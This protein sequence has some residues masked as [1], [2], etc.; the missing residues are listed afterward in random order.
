MIK[1]FPNWASVFDTAEYG[2]L[3]HV[4][5]E[6]HSTDY[7]T[8]E[9]LHSRQEDHVSCNA[10]AAHS[11]ASA[12][13][14]HSSESVFTTSSYRSKKSHRHHRVAAMGLFIL[15]NR[16]LFVVISVLIICKP[17]SH[18]VFS[19]PQPRPEPI[20]FETTSRFEAPSLNN[21]LGS[22]PAKYAAPSI[23]PRPIPALEAV[24]WGTEEQKAALPERRASPTKPSQPHTRLEQ[25]GNSQATRNVHL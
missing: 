19:V 3:R 22:A 11:F 5:P 13:M 12:H 17:A 16:L 18:N 21:D 7:Q 9:N 4:V 25:Q 15:G 1:A 20:L 14:S 6:P 2:P 8:K 24:M 23:G 10:R